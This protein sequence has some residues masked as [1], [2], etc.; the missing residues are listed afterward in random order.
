VEPE[1]IPAVPARAL[2]DVCGLTSG[3]VVNVDD[4]WY[5]PENKRLQHGNENDR[6][7]LR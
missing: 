5:D 7:V 4:F 1:S 6:T 2:G 3:P